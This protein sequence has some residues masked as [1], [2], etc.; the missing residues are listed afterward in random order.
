MFFGNGSGLAVPILP[1]FKERGKFTDHL[2]CSGRFRLCV[3]KKNPVPFPREPVGKVAN[4]VFS[5][6]KVEAPD[7][8]QYIH[9][10]Y[11][12]RTYFSVLHFVRIAAAHCQGLHTP[13]RSARGRPYARCSRGCRAGN[14]PPGGLAAGIRHQ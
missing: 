8:K 12:I 6:A 11:D 13:R 9:D 4:M 3:N 10:G 7:D 2:R 5:A 1:V 14:H